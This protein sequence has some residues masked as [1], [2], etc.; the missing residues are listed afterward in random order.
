MSLYLYKRQRLVSAKRAVGV[1]QLQRICKGR[2]IKRP[3][4]VF[5]RSM[6]LSKVTA[7]HIAYHERLGL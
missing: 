2:K 7:P 3:R 4:Y 5:L 6:V 1:L